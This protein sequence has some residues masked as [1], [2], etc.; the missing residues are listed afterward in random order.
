VEQAVSF[1]A[2]AIRSFVD[3][4]TDKTDLIGTE[5]RPDSRHPKVGGRGP[6]I[7]QPVRE[8]VA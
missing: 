1:H 6:R 7:K 5:F 2:K 8:K 3:A 4:V